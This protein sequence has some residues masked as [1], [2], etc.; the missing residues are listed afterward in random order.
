MNGFRSIPGFRATGVVCRIFTSLMICAS[1][2][3][4]P[5]Q[6]LSAVGKVLN[7]NLSGTTQSTFNIDHQE[8]SPDGHWFVFA[9]DRE[10]AGIPELF[11]VSTSGG[12][13]VKLHDPMS[14]G[15]EIFQLKISP[16]SQWVVYLADMEHDGV[17][18]LYS[19]PID[20]SSDPVRL[21][22]D[23]YV[24][25]PTNDVVSY[26]ISPNSEKVAFM[27][28]SESTGK[29][30]VFSVDIEGG[31]PHHHN[32]NLGVG[33]EV[34]DFE[35]SPDN[36]RLVYTL[37]VDAT[38]PVDLYSTLLSGGLWTNLTEV[39]DT[40]AGVD[41][42][43]IAPN[44]RRVVYSAFQEDHDDLELYSVP[45]SVTASL[46]I[47][48]EF[49]DESEVAEF[50][51]TPNSLA[52]VYL[53]DQETADKNE[54]YIVSI[55]GGGAWL[56]LSGALIPSGNVQSDF[57]ITSDSN[58]IV[59]R[60]DS[61]IDGVYELYKVDWNG[62]NRVRLHPALP[63]GR[64]VTSFL[65]APNNAGV[66]FR[67][68]V[69]NLNDNLYANLMNGSALT[70]LTDIPAGRLLKPSFDITPD[71]LHVAFVCDLE[72]AGRD[73]LFSVPSVGGSI[74]KWNIPLADSTNDVRGFHITPDSKS[75]VY[76]GD[77]VV[78]AEDA[79][80]RAFWG[81]E[82]HLPLVKK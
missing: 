17:M 42:F 72:T 57:R 67:G 35:I 65:I 49:P 81:Y 64:M 13:P 21:N 26:R 76:V 59:Y 18:D 62:A 4:I 43:E 5:A 60:A 32:D 28:R 73:E 9:G 53:A 78:H 1:L 82:E 48:P 10:T 54:L 77:L 29:R 11:S 50:S 71:S 74:T 22:H 58:R 68:T 36:L 51:I 38:S 8:L 45:I 44:S 37:K 33:G 27:V 55:T 3:L 34:V 79:I 30:D 6:A 7:L 12:E 80:Y 39:E 24:L 63:A 15:E 70:P 2:A 23:I 75:L 40:Y 14:A 25:D 16:N 69:N 61:D 31:T 56:K 52:V 19:S 20:G 66:V 41:E 47:S 46:K